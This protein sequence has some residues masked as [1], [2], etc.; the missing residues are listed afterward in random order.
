MKEL[1]MNEVQMVSGARI[2]P[3]EWLYPA[4]FGTLAGVSTFAVTAFS[5]HPVGFALS[6]GTGFFV[7]LAFG[8]AHDFLREYDL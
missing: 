1:S 2:R 4:A 6:I 8:G 3:S 7:G 5:A